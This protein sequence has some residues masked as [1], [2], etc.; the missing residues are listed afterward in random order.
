[1]ILR[2]PGSP[3]ARAPAV[4][5]P[6]ANSTKTAVTHKMTSPSTTSTPNDTVNTVF[7]VT[8]EGAI[9]RFGAGASGV[10]GLRLRYSVESGAYGGAET[11][12]PQR[13]FSGAPGRAGAGGTLPFSSRGLN[14]RSRRYAW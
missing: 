5:R 13:E 1:M 9:S 8:C 12:V 14:F 7:R 11:P 4:R 2:R 10:T 3:P 6:A